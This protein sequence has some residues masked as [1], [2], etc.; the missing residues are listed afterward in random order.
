MGVGSAST[1][2]AG[3][4]C[5]AL[6]QKVTPGKAVPH[7]GEMVATVGDTGS[8]CPWA[9][10]KLGAWSSRGRLVRGGYGFT[11]RE[12]GCYVKNT[13]GHEAETYIKTTNQRGFN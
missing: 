13:L 8:G 11:S 7:A 4:G 9:L 5:S 6:V 12:L 3:Q 1:Q 2:R 10:S